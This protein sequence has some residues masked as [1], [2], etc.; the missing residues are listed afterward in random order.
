[1]NIIKK[2]REYKDVYSYNSSVA[3][4][5]LVLFKK[6]NNLTY[7]R[8][9]FTCA[10]RIKKAVSRNKIRRLMKEIVR[11]NENNVISGYDIIFMAR[12]N[13]VNANYKELSKSFY[14]VLNRSN[15]IKK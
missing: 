1:M 14:K 4:Y 11:L 13:A 12:N 10:K 8:Y 2:N 5:N 15:L 9:G 6:K 7:C 3:D